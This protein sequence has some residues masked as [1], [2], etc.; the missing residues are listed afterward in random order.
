MAFDQDQRVTADT[1]A[2]LLNMSVTHLYRLKKKGI[3]VR[4]GTRTGGGF[5][6]RE[7]LH[8]Y[9]AHINQDL[10]GEREKETDDP[11]TR[12]DH[13]KVQE[14]EMDLAIQKREYI[15]RSELVSWTE[16]V[17][18]QLHAVLEAL[19][20]QIKKRI[21]HLRGAEINLIKDMLAKAANGIA[22]LDNDSDAA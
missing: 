3:F 17:G 20:S 19:P 4:R 18:S 16:Q 5:P 21:P 8:N 1:M 14:K 10:E 13:L 7:N 6:I 15:H 22:R 12:L 9:L 2:D 11:K